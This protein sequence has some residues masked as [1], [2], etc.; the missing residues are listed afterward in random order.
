MSLNDDQLRAIGRI[1]AA[2]N[3]LELLMNVFAWALINPDLEIGRRA[4]QGEQFNRVL[5]KLR[6]LAEHVL[7][8][9]PG[10]L[11]QL[12]EWANHA[13]DVQRRRSDVLHA[14]W[15]LDQPTGKMVGWVHRKEIDEIDAS[16]DRLNELANDITRVRQ[17]LMQIIDGMPNFL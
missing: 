7:S 4:L 3:E 11:T 17:E 13:H 5:D 2:I 8:D 9:D 15:I 12:Q 14:L 1:S 6:R 16:G 10:L